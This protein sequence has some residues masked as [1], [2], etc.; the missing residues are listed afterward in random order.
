M[1][2]IVLR[3]LYILSHTIHI[4]AYKL[5]FMYPLQRENKVSYWLYKLLKWTQL[6]NDTLSS[7]IQTYEY[8]M[9]CY[10]IFFTVTV[11]K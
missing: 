1:S 6:V 10:T 5:L 11:V 9:L 4:K 8:E 2:E 7:Q 3:S